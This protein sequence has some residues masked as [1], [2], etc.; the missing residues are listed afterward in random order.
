MKWKSNCVQ[1]CCTLGLTVG[2][3]V[4]GV[5]SSVFCLHY[6]PCTYSIRFFC[7]AGGLVKRLIQ[8]R[9]QLEE[10]SAI[11]KRTEI[12]RCC[13]VVRVIQRWLLF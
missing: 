6:S 10:S 3:N 8:M 5:G 2:L 9:K 4:G 11:R 13:L 1:L 12:V 7:C